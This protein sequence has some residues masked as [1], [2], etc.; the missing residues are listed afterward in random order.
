MNKIVCLVACLLTVSVS[1]CAIKKEL[2]VNYEEYIKKTWVVED[3][4]GDEHN[5]YASFYFMIKEIGHDG[6][7]GLWCVQSPNSTYSG[8]MIFTG[9]IKENM[10]ICKLYDNKD[11][12]EEGT[13]KLTFLDSNEI[14]GEIDLYAR[15]ISHK[16]YIFRP[17]TLNDVAYLRLT[18]L[19]LQTE[20]DTW[21]EVDIVTGVIDGVGN[22]SYPAIYIINESD[23]ILY[24][25]EAGY[26]AASEVYEIEVGDYDGDGLDD[27]KIVTYFPY[28]PES[29][30]IERIFYQTEEGFFYTRWQ[31]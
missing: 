17:Y 26:Q 6:V 7:D 29:I 12:K 10:A 19:C 9:V 30:F 5:Y 4:H 24:S 21:G 25:F 18:P 3:W 8:Q 15:K 23:D 20:I 28:D 27:V 14:E 13:L 2:P 31:S 16:K 1:G 22:K 11:K